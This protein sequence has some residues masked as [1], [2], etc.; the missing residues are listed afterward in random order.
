VT[1]GLEPVSESD[2]PVVASADAVIGAPPWRLA[3]GRLR[4]NRAAL[5]ASI[6]LTL[7]VVACML[8]PWYAAHVSHTDP[9]SS[10]LDGTTIVDGKQVPVIA[11]NAS[12][13][14]SSP[15]G[16]TWSERYLLGAD[17]QGRDVAARLLYA[18][19]TSLLVGVAAAAITAVI[20]TVLGLVAG[21]FGGWVDAVIG[22]AL[23]L[24]WAFPVYLLAICLS[25]VLLLQGLS[26]G[27]VSIDPSS[28]WLPIGIIAL[29]Y[30]P[31]QARPVR[32][33]VIALRQREFVQSAVGQGIAT[34]RVLFGELLPNVVPTVIVFFPLM[35]ATD[36]LTESSLSYLS[37]G[38]QAPN[39][40]WGTMITDGQTQLY[41]RPWVSLA[42]GILLAG[43]IVLLNVV[44]DGVRDAIDPRGLLPR[45]QRRSWF[46]SRTAPPRTS[47]PRS[48]RE[49]PAE[50]ASS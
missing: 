5:A 43:S 22:R 6:L 30:L 45:V 47:P 9:F 24:M 31:Y 20:A 4:R 38:V 17:T 46:R 28:L 25:T 36:I 42:P 21:F 23:D 32:G 3:L 2:A 1:L 19:R 29:V 37:I 13:L 33:E 48:S 11:P 35:I 39:A 41:T 49:R 26:I 15:I 8:A 40:S 12:G 14:G 27:P 7:V 50:Q 18:G 44:A 10:N 34:W 16:P